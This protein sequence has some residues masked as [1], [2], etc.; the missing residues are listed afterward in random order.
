MK[1]LAVIF[2]GMGYTKDRPLL[3]Y[4]GK[5]AVRHGYELLHLDFSG[6]EWSKEQIKDTVFM[7]QVLEECLRRTRQALLQA[8]ISSEDEVLFVSKSIGTVVATAY[9]AESFLQARQICFSPLTF[10]EEFVQSGS[11]ILLYGNADPFADHEVIERIAEEKQLETYLIN[12]GNHSLE[13][14]NVHQDIENLGS[15][16]RRLEAMI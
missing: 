10:I 3:Y 4:T 8:D 2:P 5:L 11:G 12:G 1:K 16:M 6:I 15:M 14:G 13:T 7:K 9:A